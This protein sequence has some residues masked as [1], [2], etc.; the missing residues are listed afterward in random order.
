MKCIIVDDVP[1]A[2]KGMKRLV[3]GR[4]ELELAG[5]YGKGEDALKAMEEGGIELVFLDI[6]MEGISGVDFARQVG[7]EVMVVFTT[8]YS[9]YAVESYDLN[10]V[11]YLVK[12]IDP[13]RFDK[14][15]DKALQLSRQR[16]AAHQVEQAV[17]G[18]GSFINVKSERRYV[19]V[20]LDDILYVEGSRDMVVFQLKE[21][22]V[23]SRATVKGVE[24]SL[25]GER[26]MRVNKSYIVN[27][28]Q[29]SAFDANDILIGR[30]EIAIGPTYREAV[31]GRL[32]GEQGK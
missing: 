17:R 5:V 27:L 15:V 20:R 1:I 29:V 28:E 7:D 11:D 22:R 3:D 6:Q 21:S 24:E 18:D 8:A 23:V 30:Y 32:L 4:K 31:M 25:P 26:F 2:R 16:R 9:E 10:A 13:E 12:P 19:R 14:A